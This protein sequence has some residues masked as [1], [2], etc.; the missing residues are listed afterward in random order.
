VLKDSQMIQSCIAHCRNSANDIKSLA[1]AT[2]DL[3][4]KDELNKAMQSIN[5]CVRHCEEALTKT[6]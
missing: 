2:A 5:A 3:R 6:M 4:A 1:E